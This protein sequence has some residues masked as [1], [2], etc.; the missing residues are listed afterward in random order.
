MFIEVTLKSPET[1]IVQKNS[2]S[3]SIS[4]VCLMSHKLYIITVS[5]IFI[6]M[7]PMQMYW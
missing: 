1:Y 7:L 6:I 4:V 5:Q 3:Y 2:L